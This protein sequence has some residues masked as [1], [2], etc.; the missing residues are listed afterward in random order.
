MIKRFFHWVFKKE[1]DEFQTAVQKIEA[2]ERHLSNLLGGIDVAVD[3]NAND[4]YYAH[5][6]A[7]IS[8]QG[9][10]ADFVKFVDLGDRDIMEIQKFLRHFDRGNVDANP[11]QSQF[12]RFG[13]KNF[14]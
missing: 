5:S 2:K 9:Q 1:L 3:I 8:V 6:W 10:K 12:L 14:W 4:R 7:V 11:S 13:N